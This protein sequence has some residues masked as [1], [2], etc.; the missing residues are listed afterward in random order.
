MDIQEIP[1]ANLM[2]SHS[3]LTL[4]T[5]FKLKSKYFVQKTKA[6]QVP[7]M[8]S[9]PKQESERTRTEKEW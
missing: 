2:T 3:P 1:N 4:N 8:H 9:N 5:Q 6:P 7:T